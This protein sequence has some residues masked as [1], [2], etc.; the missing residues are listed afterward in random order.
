MVK[1]LVK[2]EFIRSKFWLV[3]SP[4]KKPASFLRLTGFHGAMTEGE[5]VAAYVG[6]VARP[7][8]QGRMLYTPHSKG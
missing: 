3:N 4:K 1:H 5:T 2:A 6:M 8:Q 7:C